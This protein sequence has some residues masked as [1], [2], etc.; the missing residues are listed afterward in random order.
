MKT[1]LTS[2]TIFALVALTVPSRAEEPVAAPAAVSEPAPPPSYRHFVGMEVGGTSPLAL[3]YRY[4]LLHALFLE[5]GGFG[6]PEALAIYTAGV[7]VAFHQSDRLMVYS[8]LG[9][10]A[11]LSGNGGLVFLYGRVGLGVKLGARRQHM[12]AADLGI[13]AGRY[14]RY[15]DQTQALVTDRRFIVPMA[16]LCYGVAFAL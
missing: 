12:L 8:G 9:A 3:I 4:R 5:V 10:S 6:A 15:D 13:W 11:S 2:F 14:R 1:R 7:V 16:G